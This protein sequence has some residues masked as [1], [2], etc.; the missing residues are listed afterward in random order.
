VRVILR[1]DITLAQ[2]STAA[3]RYP[4]TSTRTT[5]VDALKEV[6]NEQD[7][8]GVWEWCQA[9]YPKFMVLVPTR[10]RQQ[11][12]DGVHMAIVGL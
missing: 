7:A 5:E 12:V 6:L 10:R 3:T 4:T 8:D 11:F 9:H 1:P 2:R